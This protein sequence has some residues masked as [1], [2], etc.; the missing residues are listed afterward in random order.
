M[1]KFDRLARGEKAEDRAVAR[2][3]KRK[4]LPTADKV[5]ASGSLCGRLDVGP[6]LSAVGQLAC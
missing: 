3:K 4:F 1:G 6:L 2:G 5:G